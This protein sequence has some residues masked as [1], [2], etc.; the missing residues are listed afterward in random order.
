MLNNLKKTLQI[1]L[2]VIVLIAGC[3]EIS[4]REPQ[5]KGKKTL[6][7]V[8]KQIQ[9][10]YLPLTAD[11]ELSRDT[12]V[13]HDQGYYFGYYDI[14]DRTNSNDK[15][16]ES[17][18]LS[19]SLVLKAFKGYYFFSFHERPEWTVRVVKPEKDGDLIYMAP[20]Q[21]GVDFKNYLNK[22]S[23]EIRVDSFQVEDKMIYQIDPT[24]KE[25]VRLIEKGYFT[26][27]VLKKIM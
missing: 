18:V 27:A 22:I 7:N 14:T 6:K 2:P 21:D 13:I 1:F 20:E 16:Y 12:I 17:G 15:E 10:K 5:P 11:G 9:G 19:D 25:L 4:F 8:P 23:T 3:K 24:P 26:K